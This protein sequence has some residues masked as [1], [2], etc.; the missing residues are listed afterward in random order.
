MKH[1]SLRW[2]AFD[3]LLYLLYV[4]FSS[5]ICMMMKE[6]CACRLMMLLFEAVCQGSARTAAWL[7]A[8]GLLAASELPKD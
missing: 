2:N 8:L 6:Y 5:E 3:L 7:H 1:H 4:R